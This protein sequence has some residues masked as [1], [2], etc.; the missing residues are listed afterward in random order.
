MKIIMTS[1]V[2]LA[3]AI[4]A[5]VACSDRERAP[6]VTRDI[7]HALDQAGLSQVRVGQDREKKVV[8]LT[9]NVKSDDDKANAE[10]IAKSIA[11]D[12]VIA[13]EIGVRPA[14]DE[15]TARKVESD[16]DA[17]IDK[18]L[19]AML[20]EHKLKDDI[21][22]G[23]NNGVVTLKGDVRTQL[24]RSAVE[25]LTEQVPNVKQVVNELQVKNQ[26]ATSNR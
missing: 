15:G 4:A 24:Q 6:D 8:T 12:E 26:P 7:R 2:F 3:I 22:Y 1:T 11:G 10:R 14:G 20:E 23:I 5:T 17:G 13:N 21:H 18:N 9:G 19:S 25:K 16:L